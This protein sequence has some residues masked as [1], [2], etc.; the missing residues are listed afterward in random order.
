M[1]GWM[2]EEGRICFSCKNISSEK[3][4]ASKQPSLS[5]LLGHFKREK[6]RMPNDKRESHRAK[7]N[8]KLEILDGEQESRDG[9]KGGKW[10][11]MR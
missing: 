3:I 5:P 4:S 9:W 7:V 10:R 1:D 8:A 11:V 6:E 2:K